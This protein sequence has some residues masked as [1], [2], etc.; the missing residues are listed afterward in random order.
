MATPTPPSTGPNIGASRLLGTNG[1]QQAVDSL[2]TQINRL[3]ATVGAASRNSGSSNNNNGGSAFGAAWNTNS[4][5]SGT[6]NGGGGR[7][8]LGG[9]NGS[10]SNGGG[11]GFGFVGGMSRTGAVVGAVA[12]VG[13]ALVNYA[14]KNMASNFQLDYFGTSSAVAGGFQGSN[15]QAANRAARAT[16][17]NYNNVALNATDAARA[18]Y[19]NQ[20]T[21]GNAQFNGASN[22][23]FVS[24]Q[25]MSRQFAYA[26]PTAGAYGGALAAQQTYTARSLAS[27]N[28]YGYGSPILAGGV[29]NSMSNIAQGIFNRTFGA[30]SNLNLKQFNAAIQ[31]GGSLNVNLQALG[32]QAGWSQSTIQSYQNI[33]Q[34][35]VAAQQKGMSES[36]YYSLL[37]QAAGGNRSAVNQLAKTTGMGSSMFENQRNLNAS[38]LTR[39]NDILNSLA[40]A[41]D[42]ATK[43]VDSFSRALTNFLKATHLDTAIG[44]SSGFLAPFS[45][46]LGGFGGAFGA[47]AGLFGAARMFGGLG[48]GGGGLLGR[49]GGLFGRG[50]AGAAA[51]GEGGLINGGL[52]GAGA[53]SGGA[54][55]I[56]SLGAGG[57]GASGGGILSSLGPAGLILGGVSYGGYQLSKLAPKGSKG[58][59]HRNDSF[60]QWLSNTFSWQ[61]VKDTFNVK[62][63]TKDIWQPIVGL[64]GGATGSGGVTGTTGNSARNSSTKGATTASA[65]QIIKYAETQ[66]GVPYVWGGEQPGKAFD[67][68]GLTQWAYGKAGVTIPRVAADQQKI[69]TQV[70]TN[71]TQPGDLLFVGQPAHHVV[72]S[73]GNNKIIEAPHPGSKVLIRALNPSEFTSATRI[74]GSIGNMNSLLNE[75]T[76]NSGGTLNNQQNTMGGDIGNLSGTSEASAIASALAGSASGIPMVAS[77][78]NTSTTTGAG[79]GS[80]P[81]STGS[82]ASGHLKSYA[83]ALLGKYGWSNQWD[84]FNALEMSEAGWN[85]H[86][87][88]PSSGAYG[89]AQA[90]PASKYSSAG[91]DWKTSGETQLR[92]MMDYIKSRYG[93]PSA[94]WSFHQKNNW[95]AAGAWN[96]DKDQPATVHKGEMIIPAQQAETIRQTLVNNTFNP[97]LQRA[98]GT[99]TGGAS[100]SFGD[101]NVTLPSTYSGTAQ[102]A[103]QIGKTI[104]EAMDQ[105]LRLKNLQ[106]GQ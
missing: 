38:R 10:A 57:A 56:T 36:K 12:G 67:C 48:G 105:Q 58:Y 40:P 82:N 100:I 41:F 22:P 51:A 32:A 34:G 93:S 21:F 70:P 69:G 61:G 11:G 101:I 49:L 26:N 30:G 24:G 74:V 89:L 83:K 86:A 28:A 27:L 47:G 65:A 35:Q 54:N 6:T 73:I 19:L 96:I 4:N 2:T 5:R 8:T 66:L 77:S 43:A 29:K 104:V 78:Q 1:L 14:N 53:G 98:A 18:A 64:F 46:A 16:A 84:D 103:Q 60:G 17:F 68:S 87:T 99:G 97:N 79:T 44:A 23:A 80:N 76:D 81:K 52:V 31:Q 75:N 42:S 59:K 91:K 63:N 20:Y 102:E 88:N 62:E 7:F 55:V 92:W 9:M 72:M 94:A 15:F 3:T 71:K 45:N 25:N 85:V 50:G 95:Y 90:L 39:Q 37:G 33:L 13:S 106:I